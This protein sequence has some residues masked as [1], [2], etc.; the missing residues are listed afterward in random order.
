STVHALNPDTGE[1]LW[2][3]KLGQGGRVGGVQ[4]GSAYDGSRVYV[5]LSDVAMLPPP[6]GGRGAQPTMLGIPLLLDP[7]A[8]GRVFSL[9]PPTSAPAW[10]KPPPRR[11]RPSGLSPA[12]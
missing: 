10:E 7:A 2:Q 9:T 8:G 12:E 3:T 5:A 4:W 1:I 6:P 11:R